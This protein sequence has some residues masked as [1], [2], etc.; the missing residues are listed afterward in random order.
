MKKIILLVMM[1][2]LVVTGVCFSKD[3]PVTAHNDSEITKTFWF[4]W[5][6][7]PD[8]C[9]RDMFGR[10]HCKYSMWVAEMQA[11]AKHVHILK[12]LMSVGA[13]YCVEWE[14]T[15]SHLRDENSEKEMCFEVT[16]DVEE[17]YMT[18]NKVVLKK[19]EDKK[20]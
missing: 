12:G 19:K 3:I 17:I 11:G 6:N 13:K 18:P 4:N 8:G 5:M 14:N 9:Y 2:A 10:L 15:A 1:F 20:L 7:S 16:E